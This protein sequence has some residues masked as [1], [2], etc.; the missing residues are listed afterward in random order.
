MLGDILCVHYLMGQAV[1][2]HKPH[3]PYRAPSRFFDLYP[4]ATQIPIA[5]VS[6]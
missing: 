2:F 6:D 4:P 1:G 3:T 5:K